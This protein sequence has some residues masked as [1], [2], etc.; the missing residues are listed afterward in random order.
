MAKTS[1]VVAGLLKKAGIVFEGEVNGELPDDIATQLDNSLLTLKAATSNHPDVKKV[2]F[3]Q[4]YNGLDAELKSI[5]DELALEDGIKSELNTEPST[6]KRTVALIRKIKELSAK[7]DDAPDAGKA[8]KLQQE[9]NDLHAKLKAEQDNVKK[10][11]GDYENKLKQIQ[12]QTKLSGI[13]S[14]YKTMFDDLE[15]DAKDAAINALLTKSLQDSE[16]EFTFDEKGSLSLIRKDGT[17]L[18]GDNHT[19]LTPQSFI[20][21]SLSKILKVTDTGKTGGSNT[22]SGAPSVPSTTNPTLN[23]AVAEA[24]KTYETAS[25]S[26]VTG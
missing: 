13:L 21:K 25:K 23:N 18:F 8:A 16:A 20:D 15:P 2:Y 17:N 14:K 9:I 6:T 19:P 7:K 22:N 1:D 3:A 10:V 26:A 24:L 11:Q 12:I 4:A 5:M